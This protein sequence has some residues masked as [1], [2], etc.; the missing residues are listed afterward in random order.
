M[1]ISIYIMYKL[2]RAVFHRNLFHDSHT[3]QCCRRQGVRLPTADKAQV[4]L[5][6]GTDEA[7]KRSETADDSHIWNVAR[8]RRKRCAGVGS[9]DRLQSAGEPSQ[10]LYVW[11]LNP[12]ELRRTDLLQKPLDHLGYQRTLD[13]RQ[14]LRRYNQLIRQS[15]WGNLRLAALPAFQLAVQLLQRFVGR[16]L[17][18]VPQG[19]CKLDRK[20]V[21]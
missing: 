6:V 11:E 8:T 3:L 1:A 15:A 9:I 5:T 20:S 4:P 10:V 17:Q 14:T 13:L 12:Q 2:K 19:T 21:V 16:Q 7:Y 18:I